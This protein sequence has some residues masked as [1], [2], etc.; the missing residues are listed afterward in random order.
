MFELVHDLQATA[1]GLLRRPAYPAVAVGILALGLSAGMAVFTYTQAFYQPFPGVDADRLVSLFAAQD[2]DAYQNISYLDF[3]DLTAASTAPDGAFEGLAA[4]QPYYLASVRLEAQTEFATLE[5]VSGE[6]FSVLGIRTVIGRGLA[7]KDDRAGADPAAVLSHEWWQRTFGGDPSV[8]G[9]TIYLNYRP[10]T[11]VGVAAPDFLGSASG[12]RPNV[13]I[14]FAPFKDRYTSWRQ[15]SEDRDLP[16]VRVYGRLRAGAGEEQG[17][18]ALSRTAAGLDEA[19][20]KPDGATRKL[21]LE[22]STWIDPRSR[23]EEWTMVQVMT[24]AAGGLLLLVCANVANLLL[25]VAVRRRRETAVRVALGASPGRLIR[26]VL[27]ENVLL[28][29]LAGGIALLLAG[30]LSQRLGAYFARPSVW[31]VDVARQTS[32]DLSVIGIALLI[33]VATGLLAGLLPASRVWCRD[34]LTTLRTAA[35]TTGGVPVR[36]WGRRLPGVRQVLVSV[37]VALSVVLLVVAGLVLRTLVSAGDLDPG[38]AYDPY[39]AGLIS[40]SST[41]LEASQREAFLRQ[42]T[43]RLTEEPWVRSAAM[44]DAPLLAP[45]REAELVPEGATE[46]QP[47]VFSRVLPGFFGALGIELRQG[48]AFTPADTVDSR[49]VA[50]VNEALARRFFAGQNPLGRRIR[51]P[52]EDRSYEIVG[53]ARDTKTEDFFAPPPPTVY[54]AYPQHDYG[55]T[56]ALMVSVAGDPSLAVP[57]LHRWLRDFEPHLAIINVVTYQEI[58]RGFL[59]THRM[60]AEMF[61]IVALLGLVLSAVG[62]WSVMSLAVN[63]RMREIAVRMAVGAERGD[64]YRLVLAQALASAA[65]GLALGL[66]LAYLQAGLVRSLLFGVEPT[67]PLT[68]AVG[69]GV[70][71]VSTLG[72]AYLPARRAAAVD[73]TVS[74]RQE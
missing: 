64:I 25:S 54:F 70:L 72:A 65:L 63:G 71:V 28:S 68:L 35:T 19:Y 36:L 48:R 4:V 17:L 39:V 29:G 24:T 13:W 62:I 3:L 15:R 20:P 49:L 67:D 57:R 40:T 44:A 69:V 60:N 50:V 41:D 12:F 51:W 56:S 9:R 43:E 10:F 74:L 58:V 16:L 2:D 26:Q 27:L 21:R 53:V 11:V 33:S 30:P 23:V 59:Y 73:P 14:P 38:F 34:V 18:A 6:Y 5:A 42:L 1:R 31:G 7:A 45:H 47:L 66:A 8:L 32:V 37:Q 22:A 46:A 55:T 61:S 52:E